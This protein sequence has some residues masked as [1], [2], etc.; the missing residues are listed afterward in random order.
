MN[1]IEKLKKIDAE[2]NELLTTDVQK[3]HAD[4]FNRLNNF[5]KQNR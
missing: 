5:R 2:G 1:G 3:L 4:Y